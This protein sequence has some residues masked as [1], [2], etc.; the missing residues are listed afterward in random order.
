[1]TTQNENQ[2]ILERE[3]KRLEKFRNLA[4]GNKDSSNRHV[5]A[6]Y[7]KADECAI[8]STDSQC[9]IQGIAILIDTK[10]PDDDVPIQHLQAVK[11]NFDKLK[12]LSDRCDDSTYSSRAAHA[13]S[14]AI[15]GSPNDAKDILDTIASEIEIDYRERV[16]GKLIY[17]M[18]A[19][20]VSLVLCGFSL[21]FFI[22]PFD[23]AIN[24]ES[25][26]YLAI[27]FCTAATLGG[28]VSV[29][30]GLNEI[31]IDKGLGK[32]PYFIYGVA[33]NLFSVVGGLFVFWLIESNLLFGFIST[34]DEKLYGLLAFGFLSG[35]SETLIPNS[36]KKLENRSAQESRE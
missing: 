22:N 9:S 36:L 33:R 1:M 19:F 28:L 16:I 18:G 27:L 14:V 32:I 11:Q 31:N 2:E 25:G 17:I 6:V 20:V 7:V 21:Y 35:F 30:R 5:H 13:L 4:I 24:I 34:L 12:S 8:Y 15:S 3:E 10:D 23:H 26:L 29:S